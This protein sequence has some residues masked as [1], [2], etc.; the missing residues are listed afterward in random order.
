[1]K[2][3]CKMFHRWVTGGHIAEDMQVFCKDCG[4]ESSVSAYGYLPLFFDGGIRWEENSEGFTKNDFKRLPRNIFYNLAR[5][6]K[7]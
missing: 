3:E 1:M 2:K 5:S 6:C 4:R 7:L